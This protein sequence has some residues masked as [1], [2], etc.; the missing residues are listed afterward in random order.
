KAEA[1]LRPQLDDSDAPEVYRIYGRAAELAGL[2]IRAAEAFADA[3]F[4][5]GHAAAALDQLTRLSQRADLDYAQRAR[6]DARIAWLT[7]IV[8]DQRRLRANS[9]ATGGSDDL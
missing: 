6:I 3:T 8:L 4:L 9:G 2:K 7:P 1:L 5:S